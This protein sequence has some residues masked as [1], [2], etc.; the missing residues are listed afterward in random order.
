MAEGLQHIRDA[1]FLLIPASAQTHGHNTMLYAHFYAPQLAAFLASA[2][3]RS[4]TP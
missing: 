1:H 3:E 4:A 2:P